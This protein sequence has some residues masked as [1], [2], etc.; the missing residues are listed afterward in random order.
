MDRALRNNWTGV[1][2]V[3]VP[4]ARHAFPYSFMLTNLC[5]N[6]MVEY[7]VLSLGFQMKIEIEIKDLNIYTF[8]HQTTSYEA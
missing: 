2:V 8:G 1:S 5:S 3:L 4:P 7:Q 6:N